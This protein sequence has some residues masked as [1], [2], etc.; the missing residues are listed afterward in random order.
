M[1][2]QKRLH[3]G[4]RRRSFNGIKK[5]CWEMQSP[6]FNLFC[7]GGGGGCQGL[8]TA[9]KRQGVLNF[10]TEKG[11]SILC[12]IS[13]GKVKGRRKIWKLTVKKPEALRKKTEN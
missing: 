8:A 4:L 2:L 11:Y 3:V 13:S 7:W 9:S 5:H 1:I 10:D 12:L 6:P